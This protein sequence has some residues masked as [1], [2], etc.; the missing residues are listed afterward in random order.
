MRLAIGSGTVEI[1]TII[2]D[3]FHTLVDPQEKAPPGF[4]RL[5]AV[6]EILGMAASD[7]DLWW[8]QRVPVFVSEPISPIDDLVELARVRRIV[9]S[10]GH[11]A[12]LDRAMG[13][14]QDL[15]LRT[16]I[17]GAVTTLAGLRKRR[18]TT[19]VLS[20]AH[21]RDVRAFPQSPLAEVVDNACFS[22]FTGRVKPDPTAYGGVLERLGADPGR[23]A[24]IGDGGSGEIEGA[25]RA[26]Y[27]AA[28]AVA[29]PVGRGGWRDAEEQSRIEAAADAVIAD[30]SDLFDLD[31]G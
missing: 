25:R 18:V 10:P 6:A 31:G 17:A 3:L 12:E 28:I 21:V 14:Y 22:C 26:G 24:F 27:S 9:V 15:A 4:N 11:V 5:H 2:F 13:K 20:N 19:A 1:D 29:G 23:T 7:L 16:P 8:E 30:V